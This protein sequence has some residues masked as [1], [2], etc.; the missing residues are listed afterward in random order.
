[1]SMGRW[2][3]AH[4]NTMNHRTAIAARI[5]T[6][7]VVVRRVGPPGSRC[8]SQPYMPA[9]SVVGQPGTVSGPWPRQDAGDDDPVRAGPGGIAGDQGDQPLSRLLR[10][11]TGDR[12]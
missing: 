2:T 7:I 12:V 3:D 9:P 5:S 1:M 4:G 8:H 10:R 11:V 6:V